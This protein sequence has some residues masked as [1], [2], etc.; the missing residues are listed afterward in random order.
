MSYRHCHGLPAALVL[1]MLAFGL[2]G[3]ATAPSSPEPPPPPP[4]VPTLPPAFP[5][6]L[7]LQAQVRRP[8]LNLCALH[9]FAALA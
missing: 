8:F 3:C 1:G 2:A 5:P 6:Q 4:V 7:S 9:S